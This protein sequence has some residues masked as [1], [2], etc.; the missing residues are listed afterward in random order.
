MLF[1]AGGNFKIAS[2]VMDYS[3][4]N[5]GT[6]E[7]KGDIKQTKNASEDSMDLQGM[8]LLLD[9]NERQVVNIRTEEE[10]NCLGTLEITNPSKVYFTDPTLSLEG[11]SGLQY[12]ENDMLVLKDWFVRL[13]ADDV[14]YGDL[15]LWDGGLDCNGKKLHVTGDLTQLSA[16]VDLNKGNL[17]IAG[18]YTINGQS[19]LN[20]VNA[21]DLLQ[22]YGNFAMLSEFTHVGNLTNGR[23]ELSG[24]FTQ[25]GCISSFDSSDDFVMAFMGDGS[26]RVYIQNIQFSGFANIA[27]GCDK[28][29]MDED[30]NISNV[31]MMY[32]IA[33]GIAEG[34]VELFALEE[35]SEISN[36]MLAAMGVIGIVGTLAAPLILPEVVATVFASAFSSIGIISSGYMALRAM[37]G[38]YQTSTGTGTK[39]EQARA[40]ARDIII[41]IGSLVFIGDEVA[42]I[43]KNSTQL[44]NAVVRFGEMVQ[45][46]TD[47]I[48]TTLKSNL[49]QM[50]TNMAGL[51]KVSVMRKYYISRIKN[52]KNLVEYLD[53][54]L[55]TDLLDYIKNN[56]KD[57]DYSGDSLRKIAEV[58][59]R[60]S[61]EAANLLDEK[62]VE[63]LL[64][65][66][67]RNDEWSVD[68]LFEWLCKRGNDSWVRNLDNTSDLNIDDFLSLKDNG[69]VKVNTSG[70]NRPLTGVPNSYYKTGNGEPIFVYDGDG[71]L[72][73]DISSSRVKGF[74]INVAPNGVEHYQAYKLEGAVPDAI[75]KLFGW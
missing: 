18:D 28:Y 27:P 11:V 59:A 10:Y 55:G 72:I 37:Y 17:K 23:F 66:A 40:Y 45:S 7:V 15:T 29:I 16:Y 65:Q 63:N 75:K 22:V 50:K 74:K 53:G 70:S 44:R 47:G 26:Q 51:K 9:G 6:L 2:R 67:K 62:Y 68:E 73:Y 20:M 48:V 19:I 31:Q 8:K 35:F 54:I 57:Q 43:Y 32:S 34:I 60:T 3:C 4:M 24:D 36:Q 39:Y 21:A 64:E 30:S 14:F 69:V 56:V 33:M 5:C 46:G 71:K 25:G 42:N 38:A 49:S 41:F 12:I 52:S 58:L 1:Y 61:E 13:Q